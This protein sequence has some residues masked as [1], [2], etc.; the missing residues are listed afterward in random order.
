M[1]EVALLSVQLCHVLL[2][3]CHRLR[4]PLVVQWG[5]EGHCG[6]FLVGV[7]VPK[8]FDGLVCEMILGG[9]RCNA[10]RHVVVGCGGSLAKVGLGAAGWGQGGSLRAHW[11][12]MW[13]SR[14]LAR[15]PGWRRREGVGAFVADDTML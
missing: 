1:R 9:V 5:S 10:A 8:A 4:R 2:E 12:S 13:P 6:R 15:R 14:A 11:A 3:E 7:A